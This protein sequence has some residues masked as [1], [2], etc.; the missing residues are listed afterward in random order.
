MLAI[1]ILFIK[2]LALPSRK[3]GVVYV[4]TYAMGKVVSEALQCG[5]YKAQAKDKGVQ[6]QAWI[7]EGG[8]I[9][10]TGAL[11]TRI[12]IEGIVYVIYV[13]RLYRLTSFA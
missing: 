6:L 13:D 12:N 9:V 8:W 2:Q 4:H 5:F 10:A 11:G 1:A 3:K 7:W